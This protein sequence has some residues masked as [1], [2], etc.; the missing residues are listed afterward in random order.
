MYYISNYR[1]QAIDKIIP[2][3]IQ[4]PQI[5]SIIEQSADR[6]QAIEDILWKIA[7]NFK[8]DDSSG[9]F[10]QALAHNEN[11]KIVY[12]DKADDAFTY[13]SDNPDKE[14]YGEGHYY[15]QFSY[16]SGI[17]KSITDEKTRRAIKAKIIQNNTDCRIEDFIEA[18]KL[19]FNATKVGIYE[20]NPLAI[21][22]MLNGK[23]L[24]ISSSDNQSIIKGFLANCV[25]LKN[26]YI[27]PYE[28]D[29]FMYDNN[30]SYGD[31]R[32]PIVL[33]ETTSSYQYISQSINLSNTYQ[34]HIKIRNNYFDDSKVNYICIDAYFPE[35]QNNMPIMSITNTVSNYS[36]FITL[37]IN[38][39]GNFASK[40]TGYDEEFDSGITAESNK[41]YTIIIAY[42]AYN[43]F[44]SIYIVPKN[45]LNGE[46]LSIDTNNI[47]QIIKNNNPVIDAIDTEIYD[48]MP[49][50]YINTI[51]ADTLDYGNITLNAV[52]MGKFDLE[53][54]NAETY[55][56]YVSC[57]GE[58]QIL[59]NCVENKNH[60]FILTNNSLEKDILTKQTSYHY[61]KYH[62]NGKYLYFDG[63]SG[64][65]YKVLENIVECKIDAINIEFDICIPISY[66]SYNIILSDFVSNQDGKS[67][68][69]INEVGSL[70]IELPVQTEETI[71]ND[72]GTITTEIV[73]KIEKIVTPSYIIETDEY[74]KI[75]IALDNDSI[76]IYKNNKLVYQ[77]IITGNINNIYNNIKVGYSTSISDYAYRG[78][79]K[80]LKVNIIGID[81]NNIETKIDLDLPYSYKLCDKNNM[82]E[83]KNNGARLITV[84]QLIADISN[85][86]IYG[87]PLIGIR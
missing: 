10:L 60:C 43:K 7:N 50:I 55:A 63:K 56:Y 68:I 35:V 86:D 85:K 3:L 51:Y 53:T 44:N 70:V 84:P 28:Y 33:K 27:N 4:F 58:K 73:D 75:K 23:N 38:E 46:D 6:Y 77:D 80:N 87:N 34:E 64:I 61:K 78:F 81:D 45:I 67:M 2:Y 1:K 22:L 30:S 72:D 26:A 83:Y 25:Q 74:S 31:T 32:Y 54:Y 17:N 5:V 57:Y 9:V 18:I 62:S 19:Y 39:N 71:E 29:I 21:S 16:I 12:T 69:Y 15:S 47:L 37:H 82:Y 24:E 59:F 11:T 14:A 8:I 20:S 41:N 76:Q 66:K 65:D 40:I 79:I 48:K 42:S 36:N 52:V 49:L 13:G